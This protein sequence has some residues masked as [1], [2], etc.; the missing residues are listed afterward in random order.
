MK[1]SQKN[2]VSWI[3][4]TLVGCASLGAPSPA[5]GG[6]PVS[7]EEG[8]RADSATNRSRAV[9][10]FSFRNAPW[11]SVLE[12]L[13][14][15][16]D[17]SFSPEVVPQG[18]F[19]YIDRDREYTPDQAI[20]LVNSYLIIKGYTLLRHNHSLL[21][22]D[23][24]DDID[25]RL[26]SDLVTEMPLGELDQRGRYEVLKTRFTLE[27]AD[28]KVAE[29]QITP[30]LS[31]V[32]SLIVMPEAKQIIATDTGD[33]LR[34]IRSIL[35]SMEREA[36]NKSAQLHAFRLQ[37]ATADEVLTVARPLLEIPEDA[38]ASE[39]KSIRISADPLGRTVFATGEPDKV[40]LVKQIVE[41]VERDAAA[42]ASGIGP[43]ES[44]FVS[45]HPVRAADP[46]AA[47]RVLQT[48][49][50]GD[51]SVRIEV[52]AA[53]GSILA[54][55]RR[56]QH[57]L[58]RE[59]I[60]ELE[61]TGRQ[62]DVI[63]LRATDPF[64]A[65]ELVEKMFKSAANP[66]F[67]QGMTNP[68]QLI[69]RGTRSQLSQIQEV[70]AGMGESDD[71]TTAR[72]GNLRVIPLKPPQTDDVLSRL[73]E[74]WPRISDRPLR[75][76]GEPSESRRQTVR[77][78]RSRSVP[79]T[80]KP[81]GPSGD[82]TTRIGHDFVLRPVAIRAAD[83]ASDEEEGAAEATPDGENAATSEPSPKSLELGNIVITKTPQGLMIASRDAA[84]LEQLNSVIQAL[85]GRVGGSGPRFHLFYLRHISAEAALELLTGVLSGASAAERLVG[86]ATPTAGTTQRPN[87]T[88]NSVV[89][90]GGAGMPHIV[91]DKRLNALFVQ[92]SPDQL[93]TI[94]D[95][96]DVLDAES[97]PEEV[98]TFPKPHFIPV[99]HTQASEV[100][101]VLKQLYVN[102]LETG[103]ES[104]S[105]ESGSRGSPFGFRGF[106][107]FGRRSGGDDRDRNG[108][109]T[110]AGQLPK[111]TI[112]V[113]Q[114]SNSVVVAAVGPLL[115]E[116]EQVVREIDVRAESQPPPTVSVVTLKRTRTDAMQQA[117]IGLLG[118]QA[119]ISQGGGTNSRS[120]NARRS[121]SS[122]GAGET[123]GGRGG[124]STA[125][126]FGQLNAGRSRLSNG[127]RGSES[128]RSSG[129]RGFRGRNN[130]GP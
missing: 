94:S 61:R 120:T 24:E 110:S 1:S 2:L 90:T 68:R 115:R 35:K 70:L 118:D 116:V 56:A 114:G 31:P 102:R 93:Q 4:V 97:G 78:H 23:L 43:A 124:P 80:R 129:R 77:P 49:L 101:E 103:Q 65:V 88:N 52:D 48:L 14:D 121:S 11:E 75:V 86:S 39:D 83:E 7:V 107:G 111:M 98:M 89:S 27:K 46:G 85:Q 45:K 84:A 63:R 40:G 6:E 57:Q 17:L 64:L 69:L 18:T 130:D 12:W 106:P 127:G 81:I 58:I 128:G 119:Q 117:L 19:N 15:E 41:Q 122:R 74:I 32:G 44:P 10:T 125:S 71:A 37:I 53:S 28:G 79:G 25:R 95:L 126:P 96:L 30:L 82:E 38:F 5:A 112:A 66:P 8:H 91:A 76:L 22:L 72:Q 13:A 29:G 92:A 51:A 33:N 9:L 26:V 99:Y 105:R 36:E 73:Q 87:S 100:A 42:V 16:A 67:V 109:A 123:R 21:C 50:V 47:L 104:R 34:A 55:A 59:T 108:G 113:D 3:A 20:D 60:A 54:Y 62:T